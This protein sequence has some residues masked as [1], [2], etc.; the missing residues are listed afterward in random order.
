MLGPR[1]SHAEQGSTIGEQVAPILSGSSLPHESELS[2]FATHAEGSTSHGA[3]RSL[4]NQSVL[5]PSPKPIDV[6]AHLFLTCEADVPLP[7]C[8]CG[9]SGDHRSH[10]VASKLWCRHQ[11]YDHR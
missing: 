8:V 7:D 9:P 3:R 1:L 11:R 6:V 5:I 2:D 10:P 4:F